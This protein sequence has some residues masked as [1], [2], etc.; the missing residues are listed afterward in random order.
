MNN[1]WNTVPLEDYEQHMQHQTGG[2]LQL[3]NEL[4]K[5]YLKEITPKTVIF[6]GISGGNGEHIDSS[7]TNQVF[8]I[9]I[10]KKY[11]EETKKRFKDHL[12]NFN[13]IN[14]DISSSKH[15]ITIARANLIWAALIFEYVKIGKCFEF[16]NNNIQ[17][18]GHLIVT[19]QA[20]NGASSVSQTG[21]ETIK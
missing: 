13:L 2:Q 21:I 9:E 11:L 20:N 6:L 3:L 18:N 19:I 15:K 4:T 10:N 5:K 14:L 8:G 17:D 7:I 12:P 16:I 1:V